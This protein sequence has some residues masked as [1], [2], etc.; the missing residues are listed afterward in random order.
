MNYET[1]RRCDRKNTG[2]VKMN[3]GVLT[4]YRTQYTWDSSICNLFL[5]GQFPGVRVLIADVSEHTTVIPNC[6]VLIYILPLHY[7]LTTNRPAR[8]HLFP[9]GSATSPLQT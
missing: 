3:V 7:P 4:I 5:F 2:L 6:T 9:I 1:G 8:A